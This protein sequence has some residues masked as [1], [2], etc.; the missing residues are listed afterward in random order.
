MTRCKLGISFGSDSL[1]YSFPADHPMNKSRLTL[2]AQG[3]EEMANQEPM[4][5]SI[6]VIQPVAATEEDLLVFHKKDYIEHVKKLSKTG[7]G[8]LNFYDTPAFKGVYEASLFPV[9]STLAGLRGIMDGR[10][11]HFFNPVGGLHHASED[12]AR[13]FCV[14]NDSTIA[15]CKALTEFKLG[16]VAYIDI[17]AH[18]GDGIYYEFEPDPRVIICDIHEDGNYLYPGTGNE[19]ETGKAF[20]IGTKLNIPLPP[21][22]TDAGFFSA[23]DRAEEFV[24]ASKPEFIFFQ[25][26]AD[27]LSGDPTADLRYTAAAHAYATKRF[28]HLAHDICKGRILAMGGGGYNAVNVSAAWSAVVRE[29]SGID[30]K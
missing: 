22:S 9:G 28:H 15:I 25:C 3:L 1:L 27:G 30:G 10:F 18:H 26:G 4:S 8:D 13:G 12:E 19:R 16:S 11:D 7:D 24:R 2:F 29:L 21:G 20:G 5:S 17:D 23:V 6:K 14:F